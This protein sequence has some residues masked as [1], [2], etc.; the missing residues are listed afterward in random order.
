VAAGAAVVF[1]DIR[2]DPVLTARQLAEAWGLTGAEAAVALDLLSGLSP[3]EQAARRGVTLN[4]V[5]S[6]VRSLKEKMGISRSADLVAHL[7]LH[8][9]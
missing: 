2:R 7:A 6:Q 9:L 5:R 1:R 3:A 4:T 8:A